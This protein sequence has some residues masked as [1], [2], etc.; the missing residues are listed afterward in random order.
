MV[1]RIIYFILFFAYTSVQASQPV[2]DSLT[3][4]LETETSPNMR[5]KLLNKI[6]FN[7]Y[8]I[9]PEKTVSMAMENIQLAKEIGDEEGRL[10]A[11]NN[12]AIGQVFQDESQKALETFELLEKEG[13]KA[14]YMTIVHRASNNKGNLF[15]DLGQQEKA[16]KAYQQAVS[17]AKMVKDDEAYCIYLTNLVA[18]LISQEELE[19]AKRYFVN[20]FP[21]ARKIPNKSILADMNHSYGKL[22]LEM[23]NP[24]EAMAYYK[25]SLAINRQTKNTQSIITV[26]N[27]LGALEQEIGNLDKSLKYNKE[28]LKHA[29]SFGASRLLTETYLSIAK[30]HD[31]RSDFEKSI[32]YSELGFI[33]AQ[34]ARNIAIRVEYYELLARGYE[35]RGDYETALSFH[36]QFKTTQ[37]SLALLNQAQKVKEVALKYDMKSKDEENAKLRLK[38]DQQTQ[39]LKQK[40]LISVLGGIGLGLVSIICLL[41]YRNNKRKYV[42]NQMLEEEVK[43]AVKDLKES[44]EQLQSS[45]KE[46]ERF[47]HIASHDL[48]EPLRNITSFVRLIERRLEGKNAHLKEYLQ[49]V[50]NNAKQMHILIEDVLEFSKISHVAPTYETCDVNQILKQ[51]SMG[52]EQFLIDRNAS[53]QIGPMPEIESSKGQL[54]LLFKNLIENGIVFNDTKIPKVSI[55]YEVSNDFHVFKIEDNGIGIEEEYLNK[56]FGMFERLNGRVKHS[57]SGLGLSICKKIIYRLNGDLTV[58]SKVGMG[59]TFIL[60]LPV[61]AKAKGELKIDMFSNA[62]GKASAE[63]A[64]AVPVN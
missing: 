39:A 6:A 8:R 27:S 21:V 30:N 48:K 41:L 3:T 58:E 61:D 14:G 23:G 52:M 10:A 40:N 12:L 25:E 29:R 49:F 63:V 54:Y 57:G 26:L 35:G 38:Q 42:Y 2:I 19:K 5:L 55:N 1:K 46:L 59:S 15:S 50:Q 56:I 13:K 4:L 11:I 36:K 34:K 33:E 43:L 64:E 47:A 9:D 24:E 60:S 53:I 20:A 44:N 37:D 45:N 51:V 22:M 31:Q 18:M 17:I 16:T 28:A 7:Y 62:N 32:H